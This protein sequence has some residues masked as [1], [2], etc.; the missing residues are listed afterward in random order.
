MKKLFFILLFFP[1]IGLGQEK[2]FE[3]G[4]LFGGSLNSLNG[5]AFQSK[6]FDKTSFQPVAGLLTQYNFNNRFSIKSKLLYHIKGGAGEFEITNVDFPDGG[7]GTYIAKLNLHNIKLPLLAQFNFGKNRWRFFCNTG[8]YLGYLVKAEV[9]YDEGVP[10]ES[11][12]NDGLSENDFNRFDFGLKL[13][14]GASFQ[15]SERIRIFL[16]QS[17]DYGLANINKTEI[18]DN[19][20]K[21][22]TTQ[23][24]TTSIGLTYNFPIKK[25]VF[26]GTS[27][28][29]CADY[30]E[31]LEAKEKKK[32]KWRLVLYKDGKKVGGKS[33]K[34]KSR[35]FKKKD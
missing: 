19:G 35:L 17:L 21:S 15:I 4:A 22:M 5:D 1:L 7:I 18:L 13:G 6:M 9:V 20:D 3:L 23:A 16:E 33:K 26:N 8:V 34:G 11:R 29:K 10:V 25:K 27:T 12:N 14:G 28:L 30:D 24:I 2:S 31:S 32:S